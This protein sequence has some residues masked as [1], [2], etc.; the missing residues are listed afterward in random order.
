VFE[1]FVC[2]SV[3]WRLTRS[4][5]AAI[6]G[7]IGIAGALCF[8]SMGAGFCAATLHV[9][10][11]TSV[12]PPNAI[13]VSVAARDRAK[14]VAWWLRPPKSYTDCVM[15]LHGIKDSRRSAVA[16]CAHVP[17]ARLRRPRSG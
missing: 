12:A 15:V 6:G 1:L 2:F 7:G 11:S 13:N 17:G 8:L 16:F 5:K 4:K 3:K 9:P 10:K 14:L